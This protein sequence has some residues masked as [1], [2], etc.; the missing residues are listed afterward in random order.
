MTFWD[1]ANEHIIVVSLLFIYFCSC[2]S[3]I[4]QTKNTFVYRKEEGGLNE[5]KK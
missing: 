3:E 1:F 4:G 2:V 5:S